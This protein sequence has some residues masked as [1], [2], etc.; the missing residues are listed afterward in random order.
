MAEKNPTM[1]PWVCEATTSAGRLQGRA[2][3]YNQLGIPIPAASAAEEEEAK[4]RATLKQLYD[5]WNILFNYW[6]TADPA[7]KTAE[8]VLDIHVQLFVIWIDGDIVMARKLLNRE[9]LE[10][11]RKAVRRSKNLPIGH[12]NVPVKVHAELIRLLKE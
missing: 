9:V 7:S 11:A 8:W 10:R 6:S 4:S 3:I 2:Y 1:D 12:K 5:T